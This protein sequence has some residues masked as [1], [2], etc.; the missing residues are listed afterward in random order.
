MKGGGG[1]LI[2]S[3]Y[4]DVP[5]SRPPFSGHF[6]APETH[7]FKPFSSSRDGTSIFWKNFAFLIPIFTDFGQILATETKNFAK[8]IPE[9]PVSSQK[10]QFCRP[11]FWKPGRYIPTQI[12][13]EYPP[14]MKSFKRHISFEAWSYC[15]FYFST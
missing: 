9:T 13:F 12:F 6:L 10:N 7:H 14:R 8:F 15:S 5:P 4:E 3:C 2:G 11:Y 1:T